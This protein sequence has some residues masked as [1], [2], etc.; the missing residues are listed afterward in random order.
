MD[1]KSKFNLEG[2]SLKRVV[3]FK[4]SLREFIV[5]FLNLN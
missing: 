5:T 3:E 4:I 2:L 1:D